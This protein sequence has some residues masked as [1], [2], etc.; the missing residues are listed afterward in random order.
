MSAPLTVVGIGADGWAGLGER[1]RAALLAAD[2]VIGSARQLALLPPDVA[3]TRRELPSPLEPLLDELAAADTPGATAVLASGDPML[4]G[5]GAML[6]RRIPA[7]RLDVHP[8]PS[9][10][11]LAC[12]RLG[13]PEAEVELV[14]AVGRPPD[15]VAQALQPGR[16]LVV[17]ATGMDGAAQLARVLRE[18]GRGPSRFVVLE[19][20]GG[21]DERRQESTAD[22]W[23]EQAADPLHAV[24][25]EVEATPHA[26]P[27]A[28]VPGLPD[29]AYE[30]D[31][32]LTKRHVRAIMLATLAPLPGELLWDVGGGA[33]SIAIEWLRAEP[34]AQAV[35]VE[36]DA[37]RVQRIERNARTL[38]V[39]RLRVHNGR[40]PDALDELDTEPPDAIFVGGGVAVPGMLE[41]CW[42]ALRPG[43]R[44][45]ADAVT[46]EGEQALHAARAAHGGTLLRIELSHAEPLGTLEGWRPQRPVVQWTVHKPSD[47]VHLSP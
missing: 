22:A 45:V 47:V 11:A 12:A 42:Q 14:S 21:P 30:H 10:F 26:H 41:R 4:H 43:G 36:A 9:A 3:A 28:R 18:R 24:A 44:I 33:G 8:H 35:A 31:G 23:G 17:Y 19:Q 5:L 7:D 20:L 29:D 6:A 27:L 13:W 46:L 15:V 39:P 2:E 38:G 34:T 37:E 40:A 16:R 25:I 32:Q 1:T